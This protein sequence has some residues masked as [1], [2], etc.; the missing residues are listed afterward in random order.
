[1]KKKIK[2]KN[3]LERKGFVVIIF[4]INFISF[5]SCNRMQNILCKELNAL[6][7]CSC[8]PWIV[9]VTKSCVR[10]GNKEWPF[11]GYGCFVWVLPMPSNLST[12][13]DVTAAQ[14][15]RES[16]QHSSDSVVLFMGDKKL[17]DS[18]KSKS[19]VYE[20]CDFKVTPWVQF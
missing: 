6:P 1:M 5:K 4:I 14:K 7:L 20:S 16:V 10:A 12:D 11:C 8:G 18:T 9:Q 2:N 19:S 17:H 15:L 13:A 3:W